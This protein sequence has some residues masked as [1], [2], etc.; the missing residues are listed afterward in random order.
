MQ[1]EIQKIDPNK[2]VDNYSNC[3]YNK[4]VETQDGCHDTNETLIW[5]YASSLWAILLQQTAHFFFLLM[6]LSTAWNKIQTIE[7]IQNHSWRVICIASLREK[8]PSRAIHTPP[9]RPSGMTGNRLFTVQPSTKV[10]K[11]QLIDGEFPRIILYLISSICQAVS[12]VGIG[13]VFYFTNWR[14]KKTPAVHN[15][16]WKVYFTDLKAYPVR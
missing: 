3:L 16:G 12:N 11:T 10:A 2:Y 6:N 4:S 15:C 7:T 1:L 9:F 13:S 5:G 14:K 8:F